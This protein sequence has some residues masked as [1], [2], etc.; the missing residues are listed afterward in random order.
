MV[1]R[2]VRVSRCQFRKLPNGAT[3]YL[4]EDN[5]GPFVKT[6]NHIRLPTD[7][8]P[9]T[10]PDQTTV[11]GV[12]EQVIRVSKFVMNAQNAIGG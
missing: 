2:R 12:S 9:Q 11:S 10:D 6:G 7:A 4:A 1:K 3:Y 8:T 5:S